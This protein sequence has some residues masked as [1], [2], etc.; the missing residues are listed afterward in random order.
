MIIRDTNL[1]KSM[2]LVGEERRT[3][4]SMYVDDLSIG[5]VH[6]QDTAIRTISEQKEERIIHARSCENSFRTVL[7]KSKD[8]GMRINEEKTQ[9]VCISDCNHYNVSSLC[10][11]R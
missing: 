4:T 11:R 3:W 1:E 10:R 5:E 9:L 7:N 8:I 6:D 2:G